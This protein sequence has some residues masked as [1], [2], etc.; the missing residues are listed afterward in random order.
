MES[1]RRAVPGDVGAEG[2]ETA[3]AEI[4][5]Y[6]PRFHVPGSRPEV[7]RPP[8]EPRPHGREFPGFSPAAL[9]SRGALD[10]WGYPENDGLIALTVISIPVD[11]RPVL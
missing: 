4:V 10:G 1:P 7:G 8:P 9:E 2:S 3:T 5:E 6:R 11:G